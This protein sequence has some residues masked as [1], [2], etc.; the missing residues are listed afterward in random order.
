MINQQYIN[1]RQV[2]ERY[3]I[4]R[5]ALNRLV[6]DGRLTVRTIETSVAFTK[7]YSVEEIEKIIAQDN[8]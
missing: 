1:A 7:L 8:Y 3:G 2:F 4:P 5:S 6:D